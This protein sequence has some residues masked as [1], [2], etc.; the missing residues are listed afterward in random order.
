M[1]F[2]TN[3]VFRQLPFYQ[4]PLGGRGPARALRAAGA[5]R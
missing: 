4:G 3:L 1:E 2:V 5:R